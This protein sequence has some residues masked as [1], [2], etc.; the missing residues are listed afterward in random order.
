MSSHKKWSYYIY[1]DII[2]R[3]FKKTN[4]LITQ[5]IAPFFI[6][7]PGGGLIADN[8]TKIAKTSASTATRD[9]TDLVGKHIFKKT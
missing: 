8:Y 2:L 9:L 4:K 3:L 5:L 7:S 6:A 1:S